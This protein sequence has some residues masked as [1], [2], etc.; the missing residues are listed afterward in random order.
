MLKDYVLAMSVEEALDSLKSHAGEA[1]IIAGGTDA[2]LDY[3]SGKLSAKCLVDI[4]KIDKLKKVEYVDGQIIIGAAV[5]HSEIK[6]SSLIQSKA[7]LLAMASGSVG[8]LQIRNTATVVGNVVN[9]QPAADAAVAL[10]A[11]GAVAEIVDHNGTRYVPVE[12]MYAGVGK[13]TVDASRQVVTAIRFPALQAKQ[14][15]SFVRL[16][17]RGALALPI[18]NVAVVLSLAED[19]VVEWVRIVMAPVAPKP[20]RA[21]QTEKVLQ[22]AVVTDQLIGEAA[23]AAVVEASPRSSALRGSAEYRKEVLEVLVRRALEQAIAAAK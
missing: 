7:P 2:I 20:L 17:Q 3:Q 19:N 16:A 15:S 13:S 22:G 11:L 14:G 5:T 9:A 12:E 6:E 10:V 23:R 8:S 21:S 1:R 18:L 4:S